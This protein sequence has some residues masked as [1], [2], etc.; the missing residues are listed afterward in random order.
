MK[1]KHTNKSKGKGVKYQ[2]DVLGKENVVK[3]KKA[4]ELDSQPEHDKFISDIVQKSKKKLAPSEYQT[5]DSVF[6]LG[7]PVVEYK[8]DKKGMIVPEESIK[9]NKPNGNRQITEEQN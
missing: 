3:V 1:N 4:K 7:K 2:D 9:R 5:E 8:A 6:G